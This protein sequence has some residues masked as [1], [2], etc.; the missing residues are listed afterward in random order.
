MSKSI[1]YDIIDIDK[2]SADFQL[3]LNVFGS[4]HFNMREMLLSTVDYHK[5]FTKNYLMVQRLK[6]ASK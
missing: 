1:K 5:I 2:I 3:L 4:V 6:N